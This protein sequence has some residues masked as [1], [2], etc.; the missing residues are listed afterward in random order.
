MRR[1]SHAFTRALALAVLAAL[2]FGP[3][4]IALP[5]TLG[6][7]VAAALYCTG[8]V[9]AFALISDASRSSRL[10]ASSLAFSV[11]L[12]SAIWA[13][14]LMT[15]AIVLTMVLSYCRVRLL[16]RGRLRRPW[17]VELIL[18]AGA[19][20][21]ADLVVSDGLPGFSSAVWAYWLVQSA[22][23]LVP[24][25]KAPGGTSSVDPFDAAFKRATDLMDSSV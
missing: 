25:A 15:T 13:N 24:V 8:S 3:A 9:I 1:E 16:Y 4:T 10:A 7:A 14:K 11:G 19:L 5:A 20:L 17:L 6:R 23:F 2:F 22:Y 18:G 21:A 12:A